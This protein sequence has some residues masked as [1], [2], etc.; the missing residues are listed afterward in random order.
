MDE[1]VLMKSE[2]ENENER[3]GVGLMKPLTYV[4][5]E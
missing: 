4:R 5:L 3:E 2:N 1:S